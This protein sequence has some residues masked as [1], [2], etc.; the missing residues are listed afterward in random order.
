MVLLAIGLATFRA[1]RVITAD[2]FPP[3]KAFRDGVAVR[4][5]SSSWQAYLVECAW[6]ASIYVAAL[7][8]FGYDL[9][10][11]LPGVGYTN[12]PVPFFMFLACSA[13]TGLVAAN[14]DGD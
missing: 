13:L 12:V 14:I 1:T 5:G 4:F 3:A 10:D 7:F 8:V 11:M 6:C 9:A 2:A